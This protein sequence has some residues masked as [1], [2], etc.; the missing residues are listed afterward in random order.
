MGL[1]PFVEK[2]EDRLIT[3]NTIKV[4]VPGV[5]LGDG[6][7]AAPFQEAA[8]FGRG[9]WCSRIGQLCLPSGSQQLRRKPDRSCSTTAL[10][11]RG[12]PRP[13]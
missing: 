7:A 1:K 5:W 13:A 10:A 4:G 3:V 6:A 9:F 2:D 8:G 11:Y 12:P